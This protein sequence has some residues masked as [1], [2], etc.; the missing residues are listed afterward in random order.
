[1]QGKSSMQVGI[2]Y[3]TAKEVLVFYICILIYH[4]CG[5]SI[6]LLVY[7]LKTMVSIDI[8]M[9]KKNNEKVS[10]SANFPN[11]GTLHMRICGTRAIT[12]VKTSDTK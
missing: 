3:D 7:G 5:Q 6:F 9:E 4:V 2:L 10:Q 12:L 11:A 8:V 1:M